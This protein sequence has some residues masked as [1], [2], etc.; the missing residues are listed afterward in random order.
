MDRDC[1]QTKLVRKRDLQK[2]VRLNEGAK[3]YGMCEN[4]FS[5]L[6]KNAKAGY[7][8]N[9]MVL[10]NL[11]ILDDYIEGFRIVE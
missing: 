1:T 9:R 6:V 3:L 11:E 8:I 2:F 10:V 7:K 4:S 5:A